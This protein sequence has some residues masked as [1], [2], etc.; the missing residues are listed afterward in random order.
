MVPDFDATDDPVYGM[1]EGRFFHGY[2]DSYC[3]LPLYVFCGDPLLVAYLRSS[4]CNGAKHTWAIL[5]L[6]V[7][8]FSRQW[9]GVRVVFRGNSRLADFP[10]ISPPVSVLSVSHCSQGVLRKPLGHSR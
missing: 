5:K 6:L 8:R 9:P 7:T 10:G 2:Y 3:F 4:D 1:Q